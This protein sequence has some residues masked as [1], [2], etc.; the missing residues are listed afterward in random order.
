MRGKR[1]IRRGKS[2]GGGANRFGDLTIREANVE[3]MLSR[4]D[5]ESGSDGIGLTQ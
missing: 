1:D 5:V 2:Y 4:L 3:R